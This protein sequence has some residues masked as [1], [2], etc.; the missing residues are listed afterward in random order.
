MKRGVEGWFGANAES[1]VLSSEGMRTSQGVGYKPEE[2]EEEQG[3]AEEEES[4]GKGEGGGGGKGRRRWCACRSLFL[5]LPR[6]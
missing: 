5:C 3:K 4:G 2:E 6:L 1:S